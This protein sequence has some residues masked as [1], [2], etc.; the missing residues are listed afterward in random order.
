ML[1]SFFLS[2]HYFY[3]LFYLS[4]NNVPQMAVSTQDVTSPISLP[5]FILCRIFLSSSTLRSIH[6]SHVLSSWS[7]PSF[8]STTFENFSVVSDLIS[9]VSKFQHHSKVCS[10]FRTSLVSS[11]NLNPIFRRKAFL[12][13]NATILYLILHV[14]FASFVVVLPKSL[15]YSTFFNCFYVI[16]SKVDGSLEILITL[17]LS[18]FIFVS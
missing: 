9:E 14:H 3:S 13:L 8:S 12:L 17:V 16:I 18:T 1:T 6:L 15:K 10:T 5:V 4:F 2:F 11:L 7:S